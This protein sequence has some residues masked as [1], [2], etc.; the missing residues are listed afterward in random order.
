MA[1]SAAEIEQI[2]SVV[3]ARLRSMNALQ[4]NVPAATSTNTQEPAPSVPVSEL[5]IDEK[6]VTLESL[7]GKLS[8]VQTVAVRSSAIITPA[9]IDELKDHKISL[10]RKSFEAQAEAKPFSPSNL[11]DD[12]GAYLFV[13]ETTEP[14]MNQLP[15]QVLQSR[16]NQVADAK[17][18]AAHINGGGKAAVW[19]TDKPFAAATITAATPALKH[20]HLRA[21]EEISTALK[22]VVPNVVVVDS[23]QWNERMIVELL[24]IWSG[25]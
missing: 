18:I 8:D 2:V 4:L 15:G 11:A 24:R 21:P 25:A 19:C 10:V 7:R 23:R 17:R 12:P 14:R 13:M 16:S 1:Q 22:E 3:L 9:V 5:V 20:V 6:L